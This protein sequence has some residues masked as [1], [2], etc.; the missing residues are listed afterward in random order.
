MKECRACGACSKKTSYLQEVAKNR[1]QLKWYTCFSHGVLSVDGS[2]NHSTL[3]HAFSLARY[4]SSTNSTLVSYLTVQN[5]YK[6]PT[7][8]N[9]V[10]PVLMIVILPLNTLIWAGTTAATGSATK[11]ITGR[12]KK[13]NDNQGSQHIQHALS[14]L[15]LHNDGAVAKAGSGEAKD[16]KG[17]TA[18]LQAASH[19]TWGEVRNL[20]LSGADLVAADG[21][22]LTAL[23]YTAFYG[24]AEL[25]RT[26]IEHGQAGLVLG[27]AHV[28]DGGEISLLL[29]CAR[30]HLDVVELLIKAGGEEHHLKTNK[31]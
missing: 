24:S 19:Q 12:S 14:S 1:F 16:A 21:Q 29:A 4:N 13:V 5:Y 6:V 9:P 18:L 7:I 23:H 2:F 28:G 15:V 20:I 8:T 31:D 17:M 11:N 25:A 22:G 3:F 30:G 26:L 10:V 27:E